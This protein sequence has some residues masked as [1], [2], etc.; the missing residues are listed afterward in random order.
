MTYVL[1]LRININIIYK[2]SSEN[3]HC[4]G[5]AYETCKKSTPPQL[6]LLLLYSYHLGYGS[7]I[8]RARSIHISIIIR[9][10]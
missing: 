1:L 7:I 4:V 5:H 10:S 8:S 2:S 9:I 3:A 6:P